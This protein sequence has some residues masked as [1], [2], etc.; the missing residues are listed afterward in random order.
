MQLPNHPCCFDGR[1]R[2]RLQWR[3]PLCYYGHLMKTN[4]YIDGFNFYYGCFK[5]TLGTAHAHLKWVDLGLL[6]EA[7]APNCARLVG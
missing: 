4:V 2:G 7:L 5:G 3:W 1:E 6:A